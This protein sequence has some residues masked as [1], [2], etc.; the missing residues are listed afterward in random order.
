MSN[1]TK[2]DFNL[3]RAM[4]VFLAVAE[5]R[6]VTQAATVLGMTQSAASQHIR[7]L[8]TAFETKLLDRT[9]RPLQLTKAGVSLY[10]RALIITNEIDDLTADVRRL[11]L[12]PIPVLRIGMLASIA[13]TLMADLVT[14][15]RE[16]FAIP[17]VVAHAGL[18]NDHLNLLRTRQAD[19]TIT[20][21]AF[22]D[23]DGLERIPVLRENF[24]LVTPA[25]H[26]GPVNDLMQLSRTLP[27]VRFTAN[28]PVGRQTDQHL[29]RLRLEIPRLIDADRS[30]MVTAC[31][32]AGQGF[33]ILTPTLLIDGLTEGMPL[34][35]QKLSAP[36]FSRT[37]HAVF[38]SQELGTL[39]QVLAERFT[40]VLKNAVAK[41]LGPIGVEAILEIAE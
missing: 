34:K 19:L 29:R 2:F 5:T 28:A 40:D 3:F 10:R 22:Y 11:D 17:E 13:T 15:A 36:G 41:A 37:I 38:R 7:N 8:E 33:A 26:N 21:D 20:S 18:A 32:A 39:P 4:E 12:T 9:S 30:S 27:L 6:Q 25:C 16:R 1:R 23:V 24:L 14:I 35:V 31:V